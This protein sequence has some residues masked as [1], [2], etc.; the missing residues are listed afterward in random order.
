MNRSVW[1]RVGVSAAVSL[2]MAVGAGA[3]QAAEG[4]ESLS[5]KIASALRSDRLFMRAGAIYV[6]IKTKSG[7]TYDVTG[8][9]VTTQ[10]LLDVFKGPVDRYVDQG[11][12]LT[13]TTT[14]GTSYTAEENF[15]FL[16]DRTSG[17]IDP[18]SPVFYGSGTLI[19]SQYGIPLLT[20]YLQAN[21]IGGIGTPPGVTGVASSQAG[22]AGISLGYF[23]GDD[24]TWAVETYVLAAPVSTSVSIRGST[25]RIDEFRGS[26]EVTRPIAINGQKVITSKL[27]PPVV[28][29]GRYWGA[30]E[31]K[32]RPYTGAM[33][34][35]AIFVDA[36]ATDALNTYVGGS[37]PGD[38][39]VSIKNAFGLGPVAGFKYQLTDNW[40]ASLNIGHVKLKTVA[41]LTTRNTVITSDSAIT[42]DLGAISD[43]IQTGDS[44]YSPGDGCLE[45]STCQ[46]VAQNGGLASL[47]MK[48]I[49]ADR[50]AAGTGDGR[51]LGTFVR[52]TDTTLA[53]TIFFMSVGRSF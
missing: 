6:N 15:P 41:T 19:H 46:I 5:L 36:K 53:N 8:P 7:D 2:M 45:E 10:E 48:G 35:Y 37:N 14:D 11:I 3:A 51:T 28:M 31:A 22:T 44:V 29:L 20:S 16:F 49:I 50:A 23:L 43:K 4:D 18:N 21:N 26:G 9:V 32:F 13:S 40:H 52:K 27:V 42:K 12:D 24:H 1:S 39:T 17:S 30:K 34:M 38:T 33:A 25:T 47:I